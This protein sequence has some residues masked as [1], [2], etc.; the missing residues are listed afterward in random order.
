[1]IS[2]VKIR[3]H[4]IKRRPIGKFFYV[5]ELKDLASSKCSDYSKQYAYPKENVRGIL[6]SRR[7]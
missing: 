3:K 7:K 4:E 6:R 2:T 5:A 1:M